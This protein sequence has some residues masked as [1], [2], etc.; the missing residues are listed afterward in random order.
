MKKIGLF[1]LSFSGILFAHDLPEIEGTYVYT[2]DH[3]LS[4]EEIWDYYFQPN[5]VLMVVSVTSASQGFLLI[6]HPQYIPQNIPRHITVCENNALNGCSDIFIHAHTDDFR[7]ALSV[8]KDICGFGQV[9]KF[10]DPDSFL[11]EAD[12]HFYY[13]LDGGIKF[14]CY[15]EG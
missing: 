14:E 1:L 5:H 6:N 15:A 8:A 4:A 9:V 7:M 10:T 2:D 13:S 3:V 11:S 12:H